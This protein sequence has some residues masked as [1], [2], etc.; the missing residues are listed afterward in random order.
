MPG[1]TFP[2]SDRK[3]RDSSV[4]RGFTLVELLVV[5]GILAVLSTATVVVLNPAELLAQGRDSTRMADIQALNKSLGFLEIDCFGCTFGSPNKIYVSVPDSSPTCDNLDLPDLPVG[6][7]YACATAQ[8][9]RKIDSTGWVPVDF[10][11]FSFGAPLSAL[12][13]DPINDASHYYQ[14]IAGGSW[15]LQAVLE[16]QKYLGVAQLDGG[17]SPV[18]YEAGSDLN[19]ASYVFPSHWVK[20]PGNS[21]FGTSDFFVMKYEAKCIGN[22]APLILPDTGYHTYSNS[23]QVC[24]G[25]RYIASSP[26]GYAI[27]NISHTTAKTYCESI[28]AHLLTNDE[29]MTIARN[30]EQVNSNWTLGA[31]AS[32]ALFSGHNDNN[33]ATAL[34]AS[35]SDT[36]AYIGT[37]NASPSNQRRTLTLSN[38]SVIWDLPG[39]VWEHVQRSTMNQGDAVD[40]IDLPPCSNGTDNWTWCQ[41]SNQ[42]T[43]YISSWNDD[44]VRS[45]VGPSNDNWFSQQGVGQ[46]YTWGTGDDKATTVFL[47]GGAGNNSSHAGAFALGLHWAASSTDHTVGFRCAR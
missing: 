21:S 23:G 47:R 16:S 26:T 31:V 44:V 14:Y 18:A 42:T 24:T 27:A 12:P 7:S 43:P 9:L 36:D 29:W 2:S 28:G 10:T 39:N 4:P 19:L 11:R 1:M 15:K 40:E 35:L 41:Y 34:E 30:A 3:N 8:N 6:W 46:V 20:V 5:I 38:G 25:T 37:G 22:E 13:V 17:T 32:G 45:K 33:P